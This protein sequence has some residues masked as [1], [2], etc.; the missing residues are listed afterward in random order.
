MKAKLTEYLYK[1]NKEFYDCNIKKIISIIK[2]CL[3]IEKKYKKCSD[4]KKELSQTGGTHD[5]TL[6]GNEII[7]YYINFFKTKKNKLLQNYI[8]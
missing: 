2:K 5:N 3:N 6:V 7:N 1:S 4:I 8:F